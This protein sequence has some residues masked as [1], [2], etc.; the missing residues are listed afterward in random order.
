VWVIALFWQRLRKYDGRS[1][2]GKSRVK[3]NP[4]MEEKDITTL[5]QSIEDMRADL[6][7]QIT[8]INGLAALL[9]TALVQATKIGIGMPDE[10]VEGPNGIVKEKKAPEA[11]LDVRGPVVL[12][13]RDLKLGD[14]REKG[15]KKGPG[16]AL[17]DNKESLIINNNGDWGKTE[18][19]DSI[20]TIHG[21]LTV[22]KAATFDKDISE[23]GQLLKEKYQ[24]KGAYY[25]KGSSV[26]VVTEDTGNGKETGAKLEVVGVSAKDKAGEEIPPGARIRIGGDLSPVLTSGFRIDFREERTLLAVNHAGTLHVPRGSLQLG[27]V[28]I[29]VEPVELFRKVFEREK[30]GSGVRSRTKERSITRWFLDAPGGAWEPVNEKGVALVVRKEG[31]EPIILGSID[32]SVTTR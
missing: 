3:E 17:Y 14:Q 20:T 29:T 22:K 26:A 11:A 15:E 1:L 5:R 9:E 4:T 19:G 6:N 27:D 24:P 32:V 10:D 25:T 8:R 23:G 2:P 7:E 16:Q 13:S 28:T 30:V 31:Q 12:R 18:I 21:T